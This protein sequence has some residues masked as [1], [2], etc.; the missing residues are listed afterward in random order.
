MA[1]R[2]VAYLSG[3]TGAGTAVLGGGLSGQDVSLSLIGDDTPDLVVGYGATGT[4]VAI[5]DGAR[6]AAKGSPVNLTTQAEVLVKPPSGYGVGE[7]AASMIP[8]INGDGSPD[9]CLGS[10]INPGTLL[11]YW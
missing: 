5:A 6:L 1:S 2:Q 10:L 4:Y 8:D 9:F 11:V 7:G 3:V